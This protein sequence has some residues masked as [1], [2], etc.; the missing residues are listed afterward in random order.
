MEKVKIL[1]LAVYSNQMNE[2]FEEIGIA[3]IAS[4]L[5][6]YGY[7][8]MLMG[9]NVKRINYDKIVEFQ[10]DIVGLPT[11]TVSKEAVYSVCSRIRKLVTGVRICLG[12]LFPTYYH[13]EILWENEDIDFIARGEGELV[14][15]DLAECLSKNGNL[16]EVKGVTYRQGNIIIANKDHD[17][18]QQMD[19]MPFPS[20]DIVVDNKL[21]HVLISTSR[22]CTNNCS[23]CVSKNFWGKWRGRSAK[24]IIDEI[25]YVVNKY[26]ISS[27]D[28]VDSSF[29]DP[30][31]D[32]KRLTEIANKI[33]KEKLTISYYA[34][35]RS[36]FWRKATPEI[37]NLLKASGLC[38]VFLGIETANEV[39]RRIYNKAAT[40]E[41]NYKAIELFRKHGM[42]VSIGFINFNPYSTFD[43]LKSN[44]SFLE[45]YNY[46]GFFDKLESRF[47]IYNNHTKLFER[48]KNDGLLKDGSNPFCFEYSF[49]N[50]SIKKFSDY[51]CNFFENMREDKENYY[52]KLNNYSYIHRNAIRQFLRVF[53]CEE[54]EKAFKIVKEHEGKVEEILSGL[55]KVNSS[56]FCTLLHLAENSW[57]N[58][59]ADRITGDFLNKD[60]LDKTVS[61]LNREKHTLYKS[62][63]EIG[64]EYVRYF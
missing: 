11:Y 30:D 15:V 62:L 33:L 59:T 58:T 34:Q 27:F 61:D 51:L 23:F 25:K 64:H 54:H 39:D 38:G 42:G 31:P 40:L 63:L 19:N 28:F 29:E 56:W 1:L 57:E 4:Y 36:D 47:I 41:D 50:D 2:V 55:N 6:K 8:V 14:F 48:I 22:G 5:R 44:I 37:M 32:C 35:M 12:G 53:D 24:S 13:K 10:P 46:A 17:V 26:N 45:Q 7:E 21:K 9:S 43:S 16:A 18:I 20:K 60:F 3:S 49:I 52:G